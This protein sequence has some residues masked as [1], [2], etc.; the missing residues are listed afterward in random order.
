MITR[1]NN[2]EF[3]RFEKE[4][5][6]RR[7]LDGESYKLTEEDRDIVSPMFE[8]IESMYPKA[9]AAL[10]ALYFKLFSWNIKRYQ[11]KSVDRFL[12]CNFSRI[13]NVPDINSKGCLNLEHVECPLKGICTYDGVICEPE[14]NTNLGNCEQEVM[15]LLFKGFNQTEIAEKLGKSPDTVHN[16]IFRSYRKIGV[17]EKADFIHYAYK[18]KLFKEE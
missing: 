4:I 3:F 11:F 14:L 12:R 15:E 6:Y 17:R 1:W 8:N 9:S 2:I 16:Q 10:K 18:N 7:A 13:D 5:W